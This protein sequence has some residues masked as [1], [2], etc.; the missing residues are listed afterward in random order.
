[1]PE[2]LDDPTPGDLLA[3]GDAFLRV[4]AADEDM[5][6][7]APIVGLAQEEMREALEQREEA[8]I[9]SEAA[10]RSCDAADQRLDATIADLS[11][12]ALDLGGGHTSAPLFTRLFPDGP[13]AYTCA[14]LEEELRLVRELRERLE[15]HPLRERFDEAL[16]ENA[17]A[18][19]RTSA[20]L[21][22]AL[23]EEARAWARLRRAQIAWLLR[24]RLARATLARQIA[25][26]GKL[27]RIDDILQLPEGSDVAAQQR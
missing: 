23:E 10:Y 5:L 19:E 8:A 16:A 3:R 13:Q 24:A 4:L 27:A 11:L 6:P 25:D 21:T 9:R 12:V 20:A 26:S 14:P 15:G 18:V 17:A 2:D 7:I 22:A 1:M